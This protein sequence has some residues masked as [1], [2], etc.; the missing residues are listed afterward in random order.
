M[1]RA[2]KGIITRRL[3]PCGGSGLKLSIRA[4]LLDSPSCLP[5]CGGSG[6][7]CKLCH[8]W[9]GNSGS[10]SVWREWIEI[11]QSLR[12]PLLVQGSPSVWREWIEMGSHNVTNLDLGGLP[13]CGGSGLKC[14]KTAIQNNTMRLPPCGGSGL[15]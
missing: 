10:P 14:H 9:S 15:K 13:P 12:F 3:P 7:K 1:K 5:P 8:S 2:L 6:L 11:P 4:P